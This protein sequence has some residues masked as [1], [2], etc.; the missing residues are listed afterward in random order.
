MI[1]RTF[2]DLRFGIYDVLTGY[3]IQPRFILKNRNMARHFISRRAFYHACFLWMI[4]C[5]S[6]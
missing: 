3:F 6:L 5:L 4:T 2:M 1:L